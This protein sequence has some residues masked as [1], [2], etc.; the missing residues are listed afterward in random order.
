M[1]CKSCKDKSGAS[2]LLDAFKQNNSDGN[3][4]KPKSFV[5][6]FFN[7]SIR[8]ILF[9]IS[10]CLTPIIIL[11]VIYLLFK[12]IIL[13]NGAVDL[14]PPLLILAKKIGIN[15]EKI[16]DKYPDDYEDLDYNNPDNYEL[17]ENIEKIN[18]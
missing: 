6:A 4:L 14:M 17:D 1:G 7:I 9:V 12:T 3:E 18:L 13:N 15:K 10:L 5:F 2:E 8:T 16:E 11:F